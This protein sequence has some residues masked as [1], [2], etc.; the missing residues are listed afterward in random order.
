MKSYDSFLRLKDPEFIKLHNLN[1]NFDILSFNFHDQEAVRSLHWD[2]I[3]PITTLNQLKTLQRLLHIQPDE[4]VAEKLISNNF[5]SAHAIAALSEE[6][7]VQENKDMFEGNEHLLQSIHRKAVDIKGRTA[8]LWGKIK[9]TIA[10]PY[11]RNAFFSKVPEDVYNFYSSLPSYEEMFGDM[12]GGCDECMSMLS[13]AAYFVD[14]MRVTQ[15]YITE[16]NKSTIP[17]KRKLLERRPDLFDL[18]LNCENTNDSI[19]YL[20]LVNEILTKRLKEELGENVELE[21]GD[22]LLTLATAIYP[23][24]LPFNL[25]LEEIRNYLEHFKTSL[26]DV[27][28][29]FDVIPDADS[30]SR[31]KTDSDPNIARERLEISPEQQKIITTVQAEPE[32]LNEAYNWS[33]LTKQST[34]GLEKT[35]DFTAQ[36][37]ITEKALRELLYQNLTQEEILDVTGT[38][39]D[40]PNNRTI[41]FVQTDKTGKKITATWNNADS[42]IGSLEGTIDGQIVNGGWKELDGTKVKRSGNFLFSF[43]CGGKKLT[44]Y[45]IDDIKDPIPFTAIKQESPYPDVMHQFYINQVLEENNYLFLQE[46]VRKGALSELLIGNL[47]LDTLDRLNRFIRFATYIGWSF[48]DL[49]WALRSLGLINKSQE[50]TPSVIQQIEIAWSIRNQFELSIEETCSLWSDMRTIGTLADKSYSFFD[51]VFNQPTVFYNPDHL[52]DPKPYHPIYSPNPFYKDT[53]KKWDFSKSATLTAL[54]DPITIDNNLIRLRLMAALSINDTELSTLAGYI[55]KQLKNNEKVISLT[56]ENLSAFYRIAKMSHLMELAVPDFLELAELLKIEPFQPSIED[57]EKLFNLYSWLDETEINVYQLQYILT[58]KYNKEHITPSFKEEDLEG[59]LAGIDK[60]APSWM[61]EDNTF[62]YQNI[63]QRSSGEIVEQLKAQEFVSPE[64]V[65]LKKHDDF[66]SLHSLIQLTERSFIS[67]NIDEPASAETFKLLQDHNSAYIDKEGYITGN[68]SVNAD[69]SFLF[70]TPPNDPLKTTKIAEVKN[71]LDSV[72][73]LSN[74]IAANKY[75][76]VVEGLIDNTISQDIFNK[77]K[78][79][80]YINEHGILS[81]TYKNDSDLSFL[82]APHDHLYTFNAQTKTAETYEVLNKIKKNIDHIVATLEN[83]KRQQQ[84]GILEILSN[85]FEAEPALIKVI[86][87]GFTYKLE[88]NEDY[89]YM[90]LSTE[91]NGDVT[92]KL[93]DLFKLIAR[94]LFL[95]KELNIT[96]E[97]ADAITQNPR[98]FGLADINKNF[99]FTVENIQSIY[100]FKQLVLLFKDKDN[101]LAKYLVNPPAKKNEADTISKISGWDKEQIEFLEKD[102]KI[103]ITTVKRISELSK[104]LKISLEAGVD[105]QLLKSLSELKAIDLEVA[106]D[107]AKNWNNYLT[108]QKYLYDA[109]KAKNTPE[110]WTALNNTLQETFSSKERNALVGYALVKMKPDGIKSKN[111]LFEY[112]LIDVEMGPCEQTSRVQQGIATVQ[113]YIQRCFMNLEE[114]VNDIEIKPVWWQ[115]MSTYRIWEANR[116]VFLFPENYFD[117]S[118]RKIKSDAYQDFYDNLNQAAVTEEN[119]TTAYMNYL[120]KFSALANLVTVDTYFC[121]STKS[122]AQGLQ[123]EDTLYVFG[124]TNTEPYKYYYRTARINNDTREVLEWSYW[125]ELNVN[126]NS[127]FV[128]PVFAFNRLYIFWVEVNKQTG[129][130]FENGNSK[131][132]LVYKASIKYSFYNFHKTWTPPQTL[133]KDMVIFFEPDDYFKDIGLYIDLL[134]MNFDLDA[135]FWNKVYILNV[136][137]K[138]EKESLLVCF[139]DLMT[140]PDQID[141]PDAPRSEANDDANQFNQTLYT[142]INFASNLKGEKGYM[143]IIPG[144]LLNYRLQTGSNGFL[145]RNVIPN[146]QEIAPYRGFIDE[147]EKSLYAV[148]TNNILYDNYINNG[149]DPNVMQGVMIAGGQTESN[150]MNA[151]TTARI[152]IFDNYSGDWSEYELSAPRSNFCSVAVNNKILFAGGRASTVN[153]QETVSNVVDIYDVDTGL[154][155]KNYLSVAR[156]YAVAA[157]VG[158]LAIIAGGETGNDAGRMMASDVVDIYDTL[159]DKWENT[160]TLPNGPYRYCNAAVINFENNEAVLLPRKRKTQPDKLVIDIFYPLRKDKKWDS[161][162]F[163]VDPS[164]K[165]IAIFA[166]N[167]NVLVISEGKLFCRFKLKVDS[168]IFRGDDAPVMYSESTA[169]TIKNEIVYVAGGSG[170]RKEAYSYNIDQNKWEKKGELSEGRGF[171][172]AATIGDK[173]IFAGGMHEKKEVSTVDIYNIVTKEWT[174]SAKLSKPRANL[175]AVAAKVNQSVKLLSKLSERKKYTYSVKNI[176]GWFTLNTGNEEF[177]V[178]PTDSSIKQISEIVQSSW[179]NISNKDYVQLSTTSYS[180]ESTDKFKDL[181]F[182]FLRLSTHTVEELSNRLFTGGLHE[183]LSPDSQMVSEINFKDAYDPQNNAEWQKYVPETISFKLSNPWSGYFKEIFFYIPL[184]IADWLYTNQQFSEAKKWYE[185]IFNPTAKHKRDENEYYWRFIDLRGVASQPLEKILTDISQLEVYEDDPFDPDRIAWHRKTALQKAVV[186]KYI[187]NIIA[188]GDQLFSQDTRES[189]NQAML[190]YILADDLLGQRPAGPAVCNRPNTKTFDD[191]LKKYQ[192]DIPD[193]LI[194]LESFFIP[195]QDG[196]LLRTNPINEINSY[197]SVPEN[198]EFTA[199]WDMVADRLYKIRHCMN[200]EGV[201]RSLPL[202]D[203]PIDPRLLIRAALDGGLSSGAIGQYP[204]PLYRFTFMLER[205]KSLANTLIQFGSSLLSVIEKKDAEELS[206][207]RANQE[208]VMLR[209]QRVVKVQQL[210]DAVYMLESATESLNGAKYRSTYYGSLIADGLSSLENESLDDMYTSMILNQVSNALHLASSVAHLLPNVGAPTAMTYGGEQIGS[211]LSA[212]ASVFGTVS[213]Y[214]NYQSQK[215]S[216]NASYQRRAHEWKLQKELAE[217]DK[218]QF[219]ATVESSTIRK[220]IA[221]NEIAIH[222]KSI[223]QSDN[224]EN[225][226][227]TKF[228][229]RDM[230]QWML[231]R[232]SMVYFQFY[233]L[234]FDAALAA[235]KAFHFER[236][237]QDKY[238]LNQGYWDSLKKGL[239]SGESLLL[240]LNQMEKTYLANNVRELEIEKT[241][242]LAAL[243]KHLDEKKRPLKILEQSGECLFDLTEKLF[244]TD[245]PGHY[246]RKIKAISISI[247]AVVGPYQNINAQLVQLG[248]KVVL[249]PDVNAVNFLL[250]GN[251]AKQPDENTLRYNWR[252]NQQVALSG[253][254]NDY[255][256]FELNYRDERYLPFEGT[257]S[258]S[259]WKLRVFDKSQNKEL[260]KTISDVIVKIS[261]TAFSGGE[262]FAGAVEALLKHG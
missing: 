118:L 126:I 143:P 83:F 145:F 14:L 86:L 64:G 119:I 111:D 148:Q 101:A 250:G 196:I 201:V 41:T 136:K 173:V 211:A 6:H 256:M 210:N 55:N 180:S 244:D 77:L 153:L 152:D 3:D 174:Q 192:G 70:Q 199:C 28:E 4:E 113:Q 116:K 65:V 209:M 48:T 249:K 32:Q 78:A 181:K 141:R 224:V 51:S 212:D 183:L 19:S 163:Y 234:A 67:G 7:F 144:I 170:D 24:N 175:T 5:H 76:F 69:F 98:A 128:T 100:Q 52:K 189:I 204:V 36:T 255:G 124:R 229:N 20:L 57:L 228:S 149:F 17:D 40:N 260:L 22:V 74:L 164:F 84:E 135:S 72:L 106:A 81:D 230:Y 243:Y 82:F 146:N 203:A 241:I 99:T 168:S 102:L 194:E 191:I 220:T 226:L 30:G 227:K 25:P 108:N 123:T 259:S 110:E 107:Q 23:F 121:S 115:W 21:G 87:L 39:K 68:Y 122:S 132:T 15:E 182:E 233:K 253:G 127:K 151:K 94:V 131:D 155:T 92:M 205:A 79:N 219:E 154:W 96:A 104:I 89:L 221:E 216:I 222:D 12:A 139:G 95:L 156:R 50:I 193:F 184:L 214:F 11:Y 37:S 150:E 177:L 147:V 247:P 43:D 254:I 206:L 88:P 188:W 257:G 223:E 208:L 187:R 61:I 142:S 239:M 85:Y 62:V 26:A 140:L 44:G 130:V 93:T 198:P 129:S 186:M 157:A 237:T 90:L 162:E 231:S 49:D 160:E 35:V 245:F 251:N 60:N 16:K 58:G 258:V 225:F 185:Y 29:A 235:E 105:V 166:F 207:L 215:K 195:S 117:P 238:I 75:S 112:L 172:T 31:L 178:M 218:K 63:N 8:L 125:N 200:I 45:F 176:P 42:T 169:F 9:D 252:P 138:A 59:I 133:V 232:I 242:S 161:Y 71:I 80:N 97:E 10:S 236:D 33:G 56:V 103:N 179:K 202:F 91:R 158:N 47:N 54:L 217:Y 38:Y 109:A 1:H 171:L 53:P 159:T 66:N 165:P 114:G 73:I 248:N 262:A 213:A 18:P 137:D 34:N 120:N 246:K 13:P 240:S 46:E 261:Y 2:G 167:D 134:N 190:L 27:Y 197:F